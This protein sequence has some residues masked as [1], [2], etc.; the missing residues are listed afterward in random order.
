MNM[1]MNMNRIS[2]L[3]LIA[4]LVSGCSAGTVNKENVK[5]GIL[6]PLSG[7][8]A[9]YGEEATEILNKTLARDFA[10]DTNIELVYGDSQCSGQE[11]VTA[12]HRLVDID[13]V[14]MILGGLCSTESLAIAS[15]LVDDNML[16]VSSV[17]TH[18]DLNGM[19]PN[20]YSFSFSDVKLA[21]GMSAV[22]STSDKVAIITEQNDWNVGLKDL[23]ETEMGQ[24][25]ISSEVF[26]KGATDVRNV[27]AKTLNAKPE[28]LILNPNGGQTGATLIKQLSEYADQLEGV[29]I[30]SQ[31][32]YLAKDIRDS[33]PVVAEGM[34]I[35]D[36]PFLDSEDFQS[37][38][39][40]FEIDVTNHTD[41]LI[42]STHDALVNMVNVYRSS[43]S[44][45]HVQNFGSAK[46][47]G[48]IS[49]G[50]SFNGKTFLEDVQ[51][52]F[53]L[54]ENGEVI[55]K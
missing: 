23:M 30:V 49:K 37:F 22:A 9:V 7:P 48:F 16:A 47:N 35:V 11:A 44:G 4:F 52:A 1:N 13:G 31:M 40:G 33:A 10:E 42:A 19:S 39:A 26:E 34:T 32:V 38:K 45:E 8:L 2:L 6:T 20:F 12:Y 15:L 17:S 50:E 24:N 27:I 51:T 41:Y 54:V 25:V 46:L 53:F 5:I 29:K 18:P 36:T 3:V 43:E 21:A 55:Q 28:V 14:D